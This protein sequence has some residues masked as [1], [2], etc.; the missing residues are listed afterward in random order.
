MSISAVIIL[1]IVTA[2]NYYTETV[3]IHLSYWSHNASVKTK[4][5]DNLR[6]LSY[7][8]GLN[9]PYQTEQ[10]DSLSGMLRFFEIQN[11]DILILPESRVWKKEKLRSSLEDLYPYSITEGFKGEEIYIESYIYSRYPLSNIHK[12]GKH[13]IYSA[14][15]SLSE[16]KKIRIIACHLSSNQWH[17]SLFGGNGLIDNLT[18]GYRQRQQEISDICDSLAV[19]SPLPTFICGDFNDFSGSSTLKTLQDKYNLYDSWWK[20][21]LG[22]GATFASKGLLLR[23]D[24]IL[25][26]KE[27]QLS[28][29]SVPHIPYSDHYPIIADFKL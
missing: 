6:I 18:Q 27:I 7:N 29:V 20:G 24:H 17:S 14:E 12:I 13:Y 15:V 23:L 21:G 3:P 2:L 5:E 19:W 8:I 1:I 11:A 28:G 22:Y 4:T 16:Q 26:P 25:Y 10:K 9:T